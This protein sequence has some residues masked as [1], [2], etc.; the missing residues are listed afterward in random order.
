MNIGLFDSGIG[1]LTVLKALTCD[2]P[3]YTYVYYGD[4]ANAPYGE[5]SPDEIYDLTIKGI[6]FLFGKYCSLVVLACNT[7]STVLPRIQQ[8][9]LPMHYPDRKVLGIIRP[10]AE[11]MTESGAKEI[12][13][14]A[15]PATVNAHSYEKE[16]VKLQTAQIHNAETVT[17]PFVPLQKGDPDLRFSLEGG[18]AQ[19]FER[20]RMS[21]VEIHPIPAPNLAKAIEDSGG[22]TNETI[23]IL[24]NKLLGDLSTFEKT[25]S[26][27][28]SALVKGTSHWQSANWRK[29][30]SQ[31]QRELPSYA[32]GAQKE[33]VVD[34]PWAGRRG[35]FPLY[36]ACTHY[37]WVEQEIA[38]I[39]KTKIIHQSQICAESLKKYL[40]RHNEIHLSRQSTYRLFFSKDRELTF[41]WLSKKA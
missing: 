29:E 39:S 24:I 35:G 21:K 13:L 15:T 3:N 19:A 36:L 9:W 5:K 4:N 30:E 16:L 27:L 33:G 40:Q 32:P 17:S 22:E 7:A 28:T 11:H 34:Q 25:T 37:E 38:R 26:P 18:P 8:E 31:K 20:G 10:T 2:L 23:R 6:E 14:M 1:G 41:E 12:Y